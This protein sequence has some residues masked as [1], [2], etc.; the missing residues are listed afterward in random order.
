MSF[1]TILHY[2]QGQKKGTFSHFAEEMLTFFQLGK[3]VCSPVGLGPVVSIFECEPFSLYT[4]VIGLVAIT[5]NFL[6]LLLFP[7][8]S[9]PNPWFSPFCA[10]NS[11]LHPRSGK[12]RCGAG[13]TEPCLVWGVSE[14]TLTN[15]E[16]RIVYAKY[17]LFFS[18]AFS[19]NTLSQ[20]P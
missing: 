8:V 11:E 15:Y 5:F 3:Y 18:P 7:V 12:G 19:Q 17:H 1:N 13:E 6:V 10:S 16:S 4:F 20:D 2:C 14:V 9:Y